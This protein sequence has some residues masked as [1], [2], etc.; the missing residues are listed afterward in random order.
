MAVNVGDGMLALALEP[1]LANTRT[2]GLGKALRVLEL[3]ARMARESAEGQ[4]LEL[5]W[6]RANTWACRDGDYFRMVHKKT[7]WY[8]FITP[9]LLGARIA[10]ADE[11]RLARL[12]RF[13]TLLGLAFQ[14]Q[15]DALNL[16]ADESA[17]GKE[18]AGDLWE[19][20][21]TLILL[22]AL[23]A[24]PPD[25]RDRAA[26][27]LAKRRPGDGAPADGAKS[28]ADI[29]FLRSL[30][31][32]SGA[33]ARARREARRRAERSRDVLERATRDLAPSAHLDFLFGVVRYVMERDR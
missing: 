3:V 7:G 25:D 12:G 8:S 10:G 18:I 15:D 24:A 28:A 21:R 20:K 19:G 32:R 23:R 1:L 2:L 30:I 29:S 11:V 13:A 33:L 14:V 22:H 17:Y 9:V 16:D 27:I 5:D 6:I 4:A 26:A 31:D